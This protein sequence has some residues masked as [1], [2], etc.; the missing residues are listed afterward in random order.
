MTIP[1]VGAPNNCGDFIGS[2]KIIIYLHPTSTVVTGT[3]GD[4]QYYMK[5]TAN[6][7]TNQYPTVYGTCDVNCSYNLNIN[8][9][10]FINRF[11]T[12]A[13]TNFYGTNKVFSPTG[14]YYKNSTY[15]RKFIELN[16]V[17]LSQTNY[18]TFKSSTSIGNTYPF[19]GSVT[20]TI[21]PSLSGT[22]CNYNQYGES[23]NYGDYQRYTH[24][25][26]YYQCKL[27]NPLNSKDFEI[28]ASPI[29]NFIYSGSP[30]TANYEL[31]YRYSGGNVTFS[32][33][34]YIIG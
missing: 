16:D 26:W 24:Y 23:A 4:S 8:V 21:I 20:S 30:Y 31:A 10:D 27:T 18:G 22:V 3:T 1:S 25:K 12:G 33:S 28:W 29:T 5:L 32:S 9:I 17:R 15:G 11:S 13:T 7:I 34:T 6:T 14:V 19:S 2:R